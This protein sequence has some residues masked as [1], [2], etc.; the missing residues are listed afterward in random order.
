MAIIVEDGTGKSNANSYCDFATFS[1]YCAERGIAHSFAQEQVEAASV[2]ASKDWL[3][4]EH[5][6][7]NYPLTNTQS[8]KFPRAY[9]NTM[10]FVVYGVPADIVLASC[11]ATWLELN[12]LLRVDLSGVSLNGVIESESK[13][14][15]GMSKSVTYK[16]GTSQAF[17]RVIPND[18]K[19]L[20]AP[21]LEG[22]FSGMRRG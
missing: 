8:M 5:N 20:I 19:N 17:S 1:A 14:L 2:I 11:K 12:G 15:S 6:F 13:S 16:S 18:L 3:D 22:G 21:H 9:T 4:G 10:G 7:A